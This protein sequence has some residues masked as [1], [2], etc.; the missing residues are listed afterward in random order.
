MC[1]SRA[2][3]SIS[4]SPW[5]PPPCPRTNDIHLDASVLIFSLALSVLTGVIFGIAPALLAA[6][7][8]VQEGLKQGA[9][10]STD[11]RGRLRGALV[12][13]EVAFALVLLGGAGL[14]ARSFMRLT[15][16]DPGFVPEHATVLR[17]ALPE[18]KYE[19]SEQQLAFADALARPPARLAR[20]AGGGP[21]SLS[22]AHQRL[23]AWFQDRR[24]ARSSASDLPNTNYYSV[25]PDYFRAMGIRLIRGRL[26][27]R[28][29]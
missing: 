15:H 12:V 7:T 19:K 14:L 3:D 21:D 13:L 25:T 11:A 8:D 6:H 23:G 27:N 1:S 10:G 20:R 18:K 28:A 26:F 5:P 4:S 22:A 2:G 24:T 17:L 9:R 16:V 29:R